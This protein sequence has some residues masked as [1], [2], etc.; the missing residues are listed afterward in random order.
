MG[1]GRMG[2]FGEGWV[3]SQGG[4]AR[5]SVGQLPGGGLAATVDGRAGLCEIILLTW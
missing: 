4:W 1:A 2:E 5:G 3:A